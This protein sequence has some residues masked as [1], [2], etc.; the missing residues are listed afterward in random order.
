MKFNKELVDHYADLLLI[1]LTSE[2]NKLVLDEFNIIED[3]MNIISN[4]PNILDVEP[5]TH[6]L[7]DFTCT[8]SSDEYIES[9]TYEEILKN[10]DLHTDKEIIVPKVVGE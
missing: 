2:E 4:I 6:A 10:S 7:D 9:L 3:N 8:L 5:M 1:G